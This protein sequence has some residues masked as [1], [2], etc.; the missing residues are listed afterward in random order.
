MDG[1]LARAT[2]KRD[3][4]HGDCALT[5]I[6]GRASSTVRLTGRPFDRD[7]SQVLLKQSFLPSAAF[8]PALP[9]VSRGNGQIV[10]GIAVCT[11]QLPIWR[12]QHK[13]RQRWALP[14]SSSRIGNRLRRFNKTGLV[15]CLTWM[16]LPITMRFCRF[17]YTAVPGVDR[18]ADVLRLN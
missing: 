9:G 5:G 8:L 14:F 4:G 1:I 12:T 18:G 10:H 7:C 15:K 2:S 11:S 17:H 6:G 3:G 13:E 16:T